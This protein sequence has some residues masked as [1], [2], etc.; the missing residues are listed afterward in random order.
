MTLADFIRSKGNAWRFVYAGPCSRC[1]GELVV[2]FSGVYY[3]HRR[4]CPR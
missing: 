2:K 3:D 1:G 4:W